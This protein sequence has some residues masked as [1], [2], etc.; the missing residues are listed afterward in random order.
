[1]IQSKF[2]LLEAPG[3]EKMK[4]FLWTVFIAVWLR[5]ARGDLGALTSIKTAIKKIDQGKELTEEGVSLL[6][7]ISEGVPEKEQ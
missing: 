3:C 4:L 6:K 1:M 5:V 7:K 2:V